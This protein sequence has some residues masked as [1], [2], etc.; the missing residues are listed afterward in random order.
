MDFVSERCRIFRQLQ[1]D[2]FANMKIEKILF[3]NDTLTFTRKFDAV[4]IR[5]PETI[6]KGATGKK[7]KLFFQAYPSYRTI[8]HSPVD[9]SGY[10][11]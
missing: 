3:H 1:V 6:K 8:Q 5:F 11:I 2:L 4:F 9:S 10:R 7:F